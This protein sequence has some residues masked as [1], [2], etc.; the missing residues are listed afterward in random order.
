MLEMPE[1]CDSCR[2]KLLMGNGTSLSESSFFQLTKMK[3]VGDLKSALTS[4]TEMQSLDF[5]QLI[6]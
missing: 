6:S 4:D 5:A 1:P 2:A 3:G